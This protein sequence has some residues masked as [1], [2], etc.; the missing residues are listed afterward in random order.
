MGFGFEVC[1]VHG[2]GEQQQRW[3]NVLIQVQVQPLDE[4]KTFM[5]RDY[6]KGIKGLLLIKRFFPI[7]SDIWIRRRPDPDF[8]NWMEK[9]VVVR[10]SH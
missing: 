7:S 3:R 10:L 8:K 1:Q 9:S 5:K 2:S 4:R 6:W